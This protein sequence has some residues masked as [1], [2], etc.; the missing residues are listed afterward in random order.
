VHDLAEPVALDQIVHNLLMNALQALELVPA[1][2]RAL[3][4]DLAAG[5]GDARGMGVLTVI[6]TGPGIPPDVLPRIFEPFFTTRSEGG[7]LGLGLSL[8]ETLATGMGGTL[9]ASDNTPRGARLSLA[10]PLSTA[11]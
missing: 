10:L 11:P 3:R 9:A 6:D 2:E 1:A 7:G 8:C 4:M 5:T